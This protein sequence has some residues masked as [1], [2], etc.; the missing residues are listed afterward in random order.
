MDKEK[1]KNES[2]EFT[3]TQDAQERP[4]SSHSPKSPREAEGAKKKKEEKP[5]EQASG[6]G[7]SHKKPP[8]KNRRKQDLPPP[9]K[10]GGIDDPL[11]RG[12]S[13]AGV[14]WYLRFLEQ[15]LTPE[16]ARRKAV[17]RKRPQEQPPQQTEKRGPKTQTPPQRPN[18]K[19]R[20]TEAGSSTATAKQTGQATSY[21]E[22]VSMIKVAVLPKNYPR[23]TLSAEQLTALEDAIVQE[24]VLGA[25]CKLQFGGIHFRP[26]TLVVDCVT[27]ETADWLRANAPSLSNWRGTELMACVG[28][29]IPRAHA[30]TVFFPRSSNFET[31]K[32]LALVST[33]NMGLHTQLWKVL[34]SKKEG[35]GQLLNI[36]IDDESCEA[37]RKMGYTIFFRFGKIPVHGLRK[38]SSKKK[39]EEEAGKTPDPGAV[40]DPAGETESTGSVDQDT[41]VTPSEEEQ[42]LLD[43]EEASTPTHV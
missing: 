28:E 5:S 23:E 39:E 14:R 38:D 10:P 22:A 27:Q 7:T 26:S 16:E 33:Q 32:L 42:M 36:G 40:E 17:E 11:R 41:T 30:I 34:G 12:L 1:T 24:M 37:I 20:K 35:N 43:D 31:E 6:K 4:G 29:D 8:K 9:G 13:G 3:A 21:A 2:R 18:V 15:G 19:R 25:E